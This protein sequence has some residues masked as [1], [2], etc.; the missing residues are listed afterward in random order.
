VSRELATR[1]VVTRWMDFTA[2]DAKLNTLHNTFG[3][4]TFPAHRPG[5]RPVTTLSLGRSSPLLRGK[6]RP[7]TTHLPPQLSPLPIP[8]GV[9]G[10]VHPIDTVGAATPILSL[11]PKVPHRL[12]R[13]SSSSGYYHGRLG[14]SASPSRSGSNDGPK[15]S[16]PLGGPIDPFA[17]LRDMRGMVFATP[18]GRDL[19]SGAPVL[20]PD[21]VAPSSSKVPRL[22][23]LSVSPTCGTSALMQMAEASLGAVL[24]ASLGGQGT[25]PEDAPDDDAAAQAWAD[26]LARNSTSMVVTRLGASRHREPKRRAE[27][28]RAR[29]PGAGAPAPAAPPADAP[30][31]PAGAGAAGRRGKK[32]QAQLVAE[33]VDFYRTED[34]RRQLQDPPPPSSY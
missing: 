10:A 7:P 20:L 24:A 33:R 21:L 8:N 3:A 16:A 32:S 23:A 19:G 27:A 6:I 25:D 28:P 29:L 4:E 18:R 2:S 11:R 31:A 9:S 1:R 30:S 22:G 34:G 15:G 13:P 5:E 26:L 17:S 12:V 14:D